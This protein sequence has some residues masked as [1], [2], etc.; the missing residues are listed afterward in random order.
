MEEPGDQ[1][2]HER[3]REEIGEEARKPRGQAGGAAEQF[4]NADPLLDDRPAELLI[5]DLHPGNLPAE[6]QVQ[7]ELGVELASD[8][9]EGCPIPNEEDDP[10]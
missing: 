9:A 1:R 10:G 4:G 8:I 6:P 2:G 7:V 5:T 3:T